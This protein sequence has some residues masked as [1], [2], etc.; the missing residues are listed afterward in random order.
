MLEYTFHR[1]ELIILGIIVLLDDGAI[2]LCLH[3]HCG[4]HSNINVSGRPNLK[5]SRRLVWY[6]SDHPSSADWS[7]C[8]CSIKPKYLKAW[9]RVPVMPLTLMN[10]LCWCPLFIHSRTE[11]TEMCVCLCL[12]HTWL[13][14]FLTLNNTYLCNKII[15]THLEKRWRF[16]IFF[17]FSAWTNLLPL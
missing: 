14:M 15:Y 8:S 7:V 9:K 6:W 5:C 2:S 16:A 12:Q 13:K 4:G 1:I 3:P 11:V 17:S 10:Q